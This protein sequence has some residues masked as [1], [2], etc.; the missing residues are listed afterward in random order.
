MSLSVMSCMSLSL[1]SC[2]S[3]SVMSCMFPHVDC[4][5]CMCMALRMVH[6]YRYTCVRVLFVCVRFSF[7]MR[8]SVIVV[9]CFVCI[10]LRN[11]RLLPG[12]ACKIAC[13]RSWYVAHSKHVCLFCVVVVLV[14]NAD[15]IRYFQCMG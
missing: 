9:D 1:M 5:A 2:M 7:A 13:A 14:V 4:R 3:L 15:M 8:G 6:F 12:V 11:H 10:L